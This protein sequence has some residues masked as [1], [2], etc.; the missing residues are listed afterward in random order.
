MNK[1]RKKWRDITSKIGLQRD[2][3]FYIACALLLSLVNDSCHMERSMWSE[4]A[5]SVNSQQES[6]AINT[7]VSLLI[8]ESSPSQ[9]EM[10][11]KM[12]MDPRNT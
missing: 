4:T 9:T 2:G 11:T 7:Q 5:N 6:E 3:G 1:Y 10:N 12:K 8:G